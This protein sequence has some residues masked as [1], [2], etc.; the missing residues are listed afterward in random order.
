MFIKP[1]V[2]AGSDRV[3]FNGE[4]VTLEGKVTGETPVFY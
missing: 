4:S 1:E 2:N 3:M